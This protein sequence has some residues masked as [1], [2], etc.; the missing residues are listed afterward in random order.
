[1]HLPADVPSAGDLLY[2]EPDA[3][4][5]TA[6]ERYDLWRYAHGIADP[7]TNGAKL[8]IKA[9]Q[10]TEVEAHTNQWRTLMGLSEEWADGA[11]FAARQDGLHRLRMSPVGYKHQI[12]D[13]DAARESYINDFSVEAA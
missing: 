9:L 6:L 8:A 5:M 12:A 2:A 11:G 1:M 10:A 13:V 4:M 3:R 7:M